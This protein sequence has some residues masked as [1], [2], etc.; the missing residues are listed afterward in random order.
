MRLT[1]EEYGAYR[2]SR[3]W[4]LLK[5]QVRIRANGR[6]ERCAERSV[7]H[8]HH[9]TYERTGQERLDDLWGLCSPCHAY[10]SGVSDIDPLV[11]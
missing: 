7:D 6:C 3:P 4:A 8:I 9:R 11:P 5:R 2:A 1:D 10:M